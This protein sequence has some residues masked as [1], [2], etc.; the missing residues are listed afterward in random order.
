MPVYSLEGTRDSLGEVRRL[1]GYPQAIVSQPIILWPELGSM[2]ALRLLL[3][4]H[5]RGPWVPGLARPFQ[6]CLTSTLMPS[7]EVLD[8]Q[9]STGS[10]LAWDR[11]CKANARQW[12]DRPA[13]QKCTQQTNFRKNWSLL[14]ITQEKQLCVKLPMV[15]NRRKEG[16]SSSPHSFG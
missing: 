10:Q 5:N 2:P 12:N 13:H 16:H 4:R 11:S 7:S 3:A 1:T 8:Y 9:T 6:Y 14:L 15:W